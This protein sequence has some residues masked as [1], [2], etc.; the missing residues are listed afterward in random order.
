M[1]LCNSFINKLQYTIV[2]CYWNRN[3]EADI[4]FPLGTSETRSLCQ[5]FCL[6]LVL[7]SSTQEQCD[8]S[9]C[10][11]QI[12]INQRITT[13]LIQP[14]ALVHKSTHKF[15]KTSF[16]FKTKCGSS[17]ESNRILFRNKETEVEL[18]NFANKIKIYFYIN[19][20]IDYL[21]HIQMYQKEITCSW[22]LY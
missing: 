12:N 5:D 15:N 14:H 20:K 2:F 3:N 8:L 17:E 22:I 19:S 18:F 7:C 9:C 16:I 1:K 4:E 21:I 10:P 13:S 6:A 11:W